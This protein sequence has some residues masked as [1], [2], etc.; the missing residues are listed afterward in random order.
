MVK[1]EKAKPLITP[2]PVQAV[3]VLV[4]HASPVLETISRA[5]FYH[6]SLCSILAVS[7]CGKLSTEDHDPFGVRQ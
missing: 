5:C 4:L 3:P 7:R 2:E 1:N 6:V